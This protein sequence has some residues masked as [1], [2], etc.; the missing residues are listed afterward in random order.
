MQELQKCIS[1]ILNPVLIP[2]HWQIAEA[3]GTS[4]QLPGDMLC[5]FEVVA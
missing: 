1:C 2:S 3:L 4:S 5:D